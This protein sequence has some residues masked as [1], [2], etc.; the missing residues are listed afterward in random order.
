MLEVVNKK[1]VGIKENKRFLDYC[2]VCN[3]L[4]NSS[5]ELFN[6]E[7]SLLVAML[8]CKGLSAKEIRK[9]INNE[10]T[11]DEIMCFLNNLNFALKSEAATYDRSLVKKIG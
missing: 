11:K 1:V 3:A 8:F 2:A 5:T 4:N 7:V 6:D 10:W 9:E